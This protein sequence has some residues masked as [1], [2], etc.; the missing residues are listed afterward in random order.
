M[1]KNTS[2]QLMHL[3]PVQH[4]VQVGVPGIDEGGR[5]GPTEHQT[6]VG[7]RI[8]PAKRVKVGGASLVRKRALKSYIFPCK[9]SLYILKGNLPS[10]PP[11]PLFIP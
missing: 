5:Q 10:P 4:F 3:L 2:R 1:C 9:H 7:E 8:A 11:W 6:A